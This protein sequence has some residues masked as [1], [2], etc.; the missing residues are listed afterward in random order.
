MI[1]KNCGIQVPENGNF[2]PV[3]GNAMMEKPSYPINY[4]G[5]ADATPAVNPQPVY[6]AVS[7]LQAPSIEQQPTSQNKGFLKNKKA[8]VIT[9]VSLLLVVLIAIIVPLAPHNAK[10]AKYDEAAILMENGDYASA[11][12]LFAE[13]ESFEDAPAMTE[14]CQNTD[15]Y[16]TAQQALD[17]GDYEK[18]RAAFLA[19]GGFEDASAQAAY[20]ENAI[21]YEQAIELLSQERYMDATAAFVRLGDFRDAAHQATHCSNMAVYLQAEELLGAADYLAA[22]DLYYEL[23]ADSFP[24]AAEKYAFCANKE[25]YATAEKYYAEG[26]YYD[27]YLAFKELGSFDDASQRMSACAQPFPST[28]ELYHNQDYKSSALSLT[29]IPPKSDGSR[30]YIK[31]YTDGDVLVSCIAIEQG[32]RAKISLPQGSYRIKNAYSYGDWFGETDMFGDAGYYLALKNGVGDNELFSLKR[33][34]TY[35]LTLRSEQNTS[36]DTVNSEKENRRDF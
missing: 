31:I 35:T 32:G 15:D 14:Y 18:A 24:E 11:K 1:C 25:K 30:N 8:M 29:I 4:S 9:S 3:C 10:R 19:L 12:V 22:K 28:G 23:P 27:A 7:P 5:T 26:A 16:Q 6:A 13:L 36:G 2:C 20:C 17:N 34:Y 33:N 21:A